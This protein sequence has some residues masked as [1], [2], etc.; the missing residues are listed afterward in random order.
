MTYRLAI[1]D[2]P[3]AD[4]FIFVPLLAG[5]IKIIY[6]SAISL[7]RHSGFGASETAA[8][9]P[10]KAGRAV[11]PFKLCTIARHIENATYFVLPLVSFVVGLNFF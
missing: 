11:N 9:V 4:C 1:I 10:L 3:E 8:R 2:P 5:Q 7:R 6:F